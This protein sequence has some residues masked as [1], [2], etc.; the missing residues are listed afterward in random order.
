MKARESRGEYVW[1]VP[2][3][4][5]DPHDLGREYKEII[6]INSQSGKG[7]AAYIMESEE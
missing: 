5:L 2:Y 1:Q 7:G 4:P 3:L 6:R